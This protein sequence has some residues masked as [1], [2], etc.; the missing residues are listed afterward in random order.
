MFP[1]S[2]YLIWLFS[3]FFIILNIL[4]ISLTIFTEF[5]M[6]IKMSRFCKLNF[7]TKS[8]LVINTLTTISLLK[9]IMESPVQLI[10]PIYMLYIFTFHS[11]FILSVVLFQYVV[12]TYKQVS[13]FG[14]QRKFVLYFFNIFKQFVSFHVQLDFHNNLESAL[15]LNT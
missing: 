13:S 3:A 11:S 14:S 6:I 1:C 10:S 9:N 12:P 2:K 4:P 15:L 8:F 5:C 7:Y